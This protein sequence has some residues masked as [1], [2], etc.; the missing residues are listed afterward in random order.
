M[1]DDALVQKALDEIAKHESAATRLKRWVN[2]ADQMMGMEPRFPDAAEWGPPWA[3]ASATNQRNSGGTTGKKYGTGAF[4]NKA[5]ASAVRVILTD[6]FEAAGQTPSPATVDEIHDAL[7]QGSFA[8]ETSGPDAQKNSIRISLG[9]NSVTF[10]KLPNS[11]HFG[12][13][14]W[15]GGVA[16]RKRSR[17]QEVLD[18][19]IANR[20]EPDDTETADEE[21]SES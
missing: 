12:L 14:E 9:K 11:E 10:V 21:S 18:R 8:F 1:A 16:K 2:E 6:R 3:A 5:F 19:A 7:L 20:D 4:F 17:L 13:V 15:Y